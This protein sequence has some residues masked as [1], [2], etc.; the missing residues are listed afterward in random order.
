MTTLL[1]A[2]AEVAPPVSGGLYALRIAGA[3]FAV[4]FFFAAMWRYRR[5][6]ISRLNLLISWFISLSVVALAI[7]PSFFNWA[8]DLFPQQQ[9]RRL[10]AVL[11]IAI[12]VLFFL[13][14]RVQAEADVA[15]RSIR[16]LVEALGQQAFDWERA[17]TL[18]EG[19]RLVTVSPAFNEA[20]NVAGVI[21]AIPKECEG[22]HVVPLV[23]S[24]GSDDRTAEVARAAGAFV[25]ELPIRRG[26][27]L[28][29]RVGYDIALKLGA[30]VVVTL[31]ADGQ[32]MP[33]ELGVVIGPI[34][35]NEADY[36]NGSRLLGYFEKEST[37][38]HL[39]VHFFS[40][41]VTILTGTRVTDISSGFRAARA[42]LLRNLV[43]KQDQF[44]TSE[45]LIEALR[46]RAKIVEVPITIL[47]RKGGKSKKPK[48]LRYGWNFSKVILQTWLR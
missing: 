39:G 13:F 10:I 18:P 4:G 6:Q 45:I 38:R 43:L 3:L 21:E 46:H 48:S 36:V 33:D 7:D 31:D 44:W 25:A 14:L 26:G 28:A 8:F 24:D 29:L 9:N 2:V 11:F 20:E 30:D 40:W 19:P 12:S 1:R 27:G 5:R 35:R 42:D 32:H 22:Y 34:V 47:A 16:L 17:A 37:I 23:V 15:E 41:L